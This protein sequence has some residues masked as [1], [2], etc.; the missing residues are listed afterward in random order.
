MP[1][2][3][4]PDE[5]D[6]AEGKVAAK[7]LLFLITE[8]GNAVQ[9]GDDEVQVEVDLQGAG[10][11]DVVRASITATR[12]SEL[13]IVFTEIHAEVDSGLV[14]NGQLVTGELNVELEDVSLVVSRPALL[15][16]SDGDI[17]EMVVDLNAP[18]WLTLVDPVS[19]TIQEAAFADLVNVV[20]R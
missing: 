7:F 20:I 5:A 2:S 1:T 4:E 11:V 17:V 16:V 8:G 3:H 13:R 6:E 18:A 14:I 15:D 19:R 12:Y 10:E 9:L